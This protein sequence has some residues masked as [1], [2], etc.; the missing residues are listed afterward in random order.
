MTIHP[1]LLALV[2]DT[3]LVALDRVGAG[4]PGRLVAKMELLNPGGS[5]KDRIGFAM[6]EAAEREGALRPGGVIV[7]PTSGN[8]GVGLAIAAARKGYRCIFVMPDKMSQEKISLL[9]AYGAE[10]VVCPTEVAPESPRS[11]YSVA[12]RLAE[13]IPGAMQPNQYYNM[14]NPQAH[15]QATGPEIWEQT[16]GKVAA[17]VAGVGTGGT[18]SGVGRYL[19]ERNPD[20][21]IVGADPE[22]SIYTD[23]DDIHP[24][25][26]E[27]IGEDFWPAT[28]DR[29]IVDRWERVSDRETFLMTRRITQE[30]G[31]LVGG[32]SGTA[33][34]A[35][36]RVAADMSKGDIVVVLLPDGG[37]SYLSKI[38]NDGWMSQHGF[39]EKREGQAKV[40][41]VLALKSSDVPGVVHVHPHERVGAAIEVMREFGV[42]QLPVV[43]S[44]D[45]EHPGDVIGSIKERDLLEVVLREPDA[46]ERPVAEIMQ[47]PL[48]MV[49]TEE[50]LE[51]LVANL[52]AGAPAVIVLD[53]SKPVGVITRADLLTF[54]AA[55]SAQR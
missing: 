29:D 31:I 34:V 21:L 47:P 24:Y 5:V 12:S 14:A 37:R 18:I 15:Y 17:F 52:G 32:S 6:I 48:P 36:L 45:S 9:R 11:Y 42:S 8:T 28:F 2:G 38:Y 16:E 44:D 41:D 19:K 13:E 1:D 53:G 43:R 26:T 27:G 4:V 7:E 46:F 50:P 23:P 51:S 10:V 33:V 54:Y 30:E 55:R 49:E 40:R 22:G 25:L 20:V 3:P 39:L 35:A